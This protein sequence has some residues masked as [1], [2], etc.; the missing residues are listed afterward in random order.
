MPIDLAALTGGFVE[1][2]GERLIEFAIG[3]AVAEALR[4]EAVQLGQEAWS[5]HPVRAL[6]AGVAANVVAEDLRSRDWGAGE[7]EQEGIDGGRFDAIVEATRTAPGVAE[8]LNVWR[9][10]L[11][12]ESMVDHGLAK[13][14]IEP[15]YR[16]AL[17]ATKVQLLPVPD[18][19]YA[20]VRGLVPDQGILPVAPPAQGVKVERFPVF[21]IDPVAEAEKQGFD[22]E[23]FSVMVG[24]SGL[25]MA[26]VM[27]A[28]AYFRNIIE[29]ADYY[30]AIAEGDVRNEYRDAILETARQILTAHDYAELRLRGWIDDEAMHAGAAKH[31]MTPA[32]ADLLRKMIGRPIPVHQV[33]TGLA[34]G[35]V[36]NGSSDHIPEAYIRSLEEGNQRP[37]WYSLSYANRYTLP[38][39]FVVRRLLQDGALTAEEATTIF[40]QSGW[41]PELAD[42]VAKAYSVTTTAA[43]SKHTAKAQT[44]LWGTLHKSY[45]VEET[46]ATTAAEMLTA[47]GV[48][49]SEHAP[50]LALW[51]HERELV[52]RTLTPSQIKKAYK[53]ATFTEAEA[54]AR[55][56]RLGYNAADA[57]TFL[58]E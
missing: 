11:I 40:V 51:E 24:R 25:A 54:V 6:N 37:E 4:P 30:L 50:I 39:A 22:R 53:E 58:A 34:R 21:N 9:R 2:A 29:L 14:K 36:F 35:G 17:K 5:V 45:V 33:T 15:Q 7:A 52:R 20:V 31:G 43:P 1:G 19:A 32:D 57:A 46:D 10:G 55:L 48:D 12:S 28:Q 18:L 56:E 49:T 47:L 27:A 23:R 41:P 13:A 42:K 8:L 26:P 38:G 3:A 16:D 44:Q